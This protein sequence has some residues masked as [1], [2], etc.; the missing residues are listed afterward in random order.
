LAAG[1]DAEAA[2]QLIRE[3]QLQGQVCI[4]CIN[5]P[6]SV[7]LSGSVDGIDLLLT[8]IQEKS[9][10]ARKLQTGGRAYHSHMMKEI[11]PLY[12]GLLK[13]VFRDKN[14]RLR[15]SNTR[16]YSSVGALGDESTG[17]VPHEYIRSAKYWRNNL[18]KPVQFQTALESLTEGMKKLHLIEIGPHPALKGPVQKIRVHMPIYL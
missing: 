12:E 15:V 9:K 17:T 13:A 2:N 14:E 10:F 7:T 6:D 4:A 8:T 11:G 3:K 16:M 1:L 5:A 18:E